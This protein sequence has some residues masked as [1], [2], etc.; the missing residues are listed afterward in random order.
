MVHIAGNRVVGD[1][2]KTEHLFERD[3]LDEF[4]EAHKKQMAFLETAER[5]PIGLPHDGESFVLDSAQQAA[6]KLKELKAI[7]YRVPDYAI[8]KL[9]DEPT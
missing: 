8:K 1:I 5:E 6:E 3:T 4:F 7:G 2:P 9:E